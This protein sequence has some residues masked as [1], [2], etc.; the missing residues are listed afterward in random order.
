MV[1]PNPVNE[2]QFEL[3]SQN[4]NNEF[5]IYSSTGVKLVSDKF[6]GFTHQISL[7]ISAG[8][9][10]IRYRSNKGKYHQLKFVKL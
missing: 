2:E 3:R 8:I 1:V 6:E 10:T 9:Y 7:N 5:E 4:T